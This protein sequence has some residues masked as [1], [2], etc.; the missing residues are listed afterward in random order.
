MSNIKL[1]DESTDLSNIEKI[2]WDTSVYN[3]SYDVYRIHG[4]IHTGGGYFNENDY[5]CCKKGVEPTY[6]T[7]IQFAG[8]VVSWGYS[9]TEN[10]YIK[11]KWGDSKVMKSCRGIITRNGEIFYSIN[12]SI[13]YL[14]HKLPVL[15]S[16]IYEHNISFSSTNWKEE[17]IGRKILYYKEP[18]VITS[19]V[20]GQCC[21]ITD[22]NEK[23]D[24]LDISNEINWYPSN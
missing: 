4:Y 13:E 2:D 21:I 19:F 17:L 3:E 11:T 23:I 14:S 20:D 1:I 22:K 9:I 7:L 12:G 6:E 24:I 16:S 8:H 18:R 10:N 15:L 5:W